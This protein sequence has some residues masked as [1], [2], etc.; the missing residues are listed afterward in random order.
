MDTSGS[1]IVKEVLSVQ[2]EVDGNT[3]YGWKRPE[4][5]ASKVAEELGELC[6]ALKKG[7]SKQLEAEVGDI[8]FSVLNLA[9]YCG[10]DPVR[11]LRE[12]KSRFERRVAIARELAAREHRRLEEL[13][14]AELDRLWEEA[15]LRLRNT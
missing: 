13:S 3:K 10:V 7:D 12:A 4:A 5:V 14:A 15:K 8:L 1:D 11:A 2:E 6:E 9:R